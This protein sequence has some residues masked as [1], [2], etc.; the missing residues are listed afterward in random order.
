MS[1]PLLTRKRIGLWPVE[2]G[3]TLFCFFIVVG[4]VIH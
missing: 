2:Y 1:F 3:P 4:F